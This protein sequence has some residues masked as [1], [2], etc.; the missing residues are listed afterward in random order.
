M[1]TTG[2]NHFTILT[3]DVPRTV[4]FY[5]D[6][7]GLDRRT[8]TAA[9]LSRGLALRRGPAGAAHRGRTSARRASRRRDRPHGV[10][11]IG[12]QGDARGARCASASNTP[13]VSRREPGSGRC[14]STIPTARKSSS[15]SRRRNRLRNDRQCAGRDGARPF[16]RRR[17]H[18]RRRHRIRRRHHR[19]YASARRQARRDGH[20]QCARC[21]SASASSSK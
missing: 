20:A 12:A 21:A 14:S 10:L 4:Q 3:D 19:R 7:L 6:L 8:A 2:L 1:A 16:D 9:R 18:A 13:A 11:G 17:G 5:G 15:I